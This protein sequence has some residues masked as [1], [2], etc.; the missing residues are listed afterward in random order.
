M[1]KGR[2]G[3]PKKGKFDDLTTEFKDAVAQST[4]EE[5]NSRIATIAKDTEALVKAQA[6][7]Q[8]Y[9]TKKEALKVAGEVYRDG[10]K[11]NRLKIQYAIQVLADKGKA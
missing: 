2:M 7:D 6:E 8:D 1:A 11:M 3:R 9:Q 5:I 10:K 4:P